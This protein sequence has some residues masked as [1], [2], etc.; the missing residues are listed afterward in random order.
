MVFSPITISFAVPWAKMWIRTSSERDS[1][2]RDWFN[3]KAQANMSSPNS[4]NLN[5][6]PPIENLLATRSQVEKDLQ[7]LMDSV[8]Q[9]KGAQINF[10]TSIQSLESLKTSSK[11]EYVEPI[12]FIC[13]WKKVACSS[14]EFSLCWIRIDWMW[15]SS[16][17]YWDWLLHWTGMH[18][19]F[20]Y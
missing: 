3:C 14:Y 19:F 16:C 9:L 5:E 15:S 20:L 7:L 17:G 6:I 13:S 18:E 1:I 10:S 2:Y 4:I 8:S 12:K 11:N